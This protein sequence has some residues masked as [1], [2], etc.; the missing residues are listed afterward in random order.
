MASAMLP[1]FPTPPMAL[2]LMPPPTTVPTT[3][4]GLLML[5]P[6]MADMAMEDVAT[7]VT[8][9][10]RLRPAMAVMAM[11]DAAMDATAR[12]RPSPATDAVVTVATAVVAGTT[13]DLRSKRSEL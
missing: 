3:A 8:A 12:G 9:R 10:G 1:A 4:R 5:S 13:V 11:A 2:S 6:A 7:D